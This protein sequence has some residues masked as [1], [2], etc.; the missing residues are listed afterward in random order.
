ILQYE[1]DN[2]K[3]PLKL[4]FQKLEY[5]LNVKYLILDYSVNQNTLD[6]V[7]VN[8]V[9][10]QQDY[11]STNAQTST[12]SKRKLTKQ[13]DIHGIIDDTF[14][15]GSFV[16]YKRTVSETKLNINSLDL[17][18]HDNQLSTIAHNANNSINSSI[19]NVNNVCDCQKQS[20]TSDCTKL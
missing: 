14:D 16:V 1:I 4:I 19:A 2:K 11:H 17:S 18:P 20:D 7:F 6:N 9:R 8:F 15:D 10:D 12:E 13:K 5:L 3:I